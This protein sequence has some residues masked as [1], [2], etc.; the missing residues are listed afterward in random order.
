MR[1]QIKLMEAETSIKALGYFN[2]CAAGF[3]W[4][5][6]DIDLIESL[7]HPMEVIV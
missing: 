5:V 4:I 1:A 6:I 2:L 3:D 7:P